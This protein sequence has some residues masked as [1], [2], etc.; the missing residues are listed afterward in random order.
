[1]YE[2]VSKVSGFNG[3]EKASKVDFSDKVFAYLTISKNHTEMSGILFVPHPL[4]Q[5]VPW[6]ES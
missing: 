2:K 1:M 4:I 5:L 6:I 3:I